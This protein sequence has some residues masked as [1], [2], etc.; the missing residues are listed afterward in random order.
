MKFFQKL[1]KFFEKRKK[2][3]RKIENNIFSVEIKSYFYPTDEKNV[4]RLFSYCR[5]ANFGKFPDSVKKIFGKLP[6][7]CTNGNF[8]G[9][10]IFYFYSFSFSFLFFLFLKSSF[11]FLFLLLTILFILSIFLFYYLTKRIQNY[12]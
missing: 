3:E 6:E 7:H 9:I 1:K 8:M 2:F 12:Q 11:F 4:I 10:R 5:S